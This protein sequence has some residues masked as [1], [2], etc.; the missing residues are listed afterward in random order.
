MKS[1]LSAATA[2]SVLSCPPFGGSVLATLLAAGMTLGLCGCKK[3]APPPPPPPV[4]VVSEVAAVNA[5]ASAEFI[6]QLD[7]PQ[8]V[9]V[10]ARVEGFVG[11][12]LFTDGTEV[13]EGDPLFKIDDQPYQETLAAANGS[14]AEARVG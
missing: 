3:H 14:L 7:S 10:R 9:Q 1:N 8:N 12:I 11:K 4:V 5:P 6:G 13:K 2:G